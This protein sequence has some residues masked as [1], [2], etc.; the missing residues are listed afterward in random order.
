MKPFLLFIVVVLTACGDSGVVSPRF[1]PL[2]DYACAN[3]PMFPSVPFRMVYSKTGATVDTSA[4]FANRYLLPHHYADTVWTT[5]NQ[6]GPLGFVFNKSE[7]YCLTLFDSLT[8][9][10][11]NVRGAVYGQ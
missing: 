1:R 5:T 4:V 10:M 2:P 7:T 6:G 11:P 8:H 3:A 9:H